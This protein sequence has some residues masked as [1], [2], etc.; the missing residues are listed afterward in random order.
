ME[1]VV[2]EEAEGGGLI[3]LYRPF[4][5]PEVDAMVH[6][7]FISKLLN[8]HLL[9]AMMYARHYAKVAIA[10][11]GIFFSL[12]VYAVFKLCCKKKRQTHRK[13]D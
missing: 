9:M 7:P 12:L 8:D 5:A 6:E 10:I 11:L 3:I 1:E 2:E 4:V 13:T